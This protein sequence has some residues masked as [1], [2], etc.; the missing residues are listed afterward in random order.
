M[1]ENFTEEEKKDLRIGLWQTWECIGH[2]ILEMN[3]GEALDQEEVIEVVLDA[4]HPLM[5][6]F[7]KQEL[8]NKFMKLS[9]EE[10]DEFAKTVFTFEFYG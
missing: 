10:Q 2:D 6:G 8:W 9:S 5:Q 3:G 4:D 1:L 7:V